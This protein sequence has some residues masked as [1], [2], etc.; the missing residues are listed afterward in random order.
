MKIIDSHVHFW[1]SD[2]VRDAWISEEMKAIRRDFFPEDLSI[3]LNDNN[4]ES[5]IAVQADQSEMET[6]FL[7]DLAKEN[8]FIKGVV[9][10]VDLSSENLDASLQNYQSEKIIKGFRHIS[11]G[12]NMGF[13]LQKKIL[14]GIE[15]L[16]EYG[17]TFDILLKQNQLLDAVKL[18]EKLPN[19]RFI[20]D[21]CG[22]PDLKTKDLK[23]WKDNISELSKNPNLYCKIS[24]LLT[25]GNLN[26]VDEKSVFEVLDFM[27]EKFGIEKLI[28]GS[29]WPVML[30]G[31]NYTL[32][33]ELI[34][35]YINQFSHEEQ[36]LFLSGNAVN[37][38]NI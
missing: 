5:C 34:S 25:Q 3:H 2:P 12:E 32:W 22:K 8:S 30:L 31:G 26:L 10:W 33:I 37:F 4:V 17:Y 28:F 24:G 16:N 36:E 6:Q 14:N 7:V 38:Y 21:H 15:K 1:K 11:E 13:L 20:L 35:K 23:S 9:G 19:Q 27:F 18:S 29:D